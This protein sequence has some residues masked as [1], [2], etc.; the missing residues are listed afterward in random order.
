ME[1]APNVIVLLGKVFGLIGLVGT[2]L[3]ASAFF[4][5][6]PPWRPVVSSASVFGFFLVIGIVFFLLGRRGVADTEEILA[7]G[8]KQQAKLTRILP[9]YGRR[10]VYR[11]SIY[12]AEVELEAGG[13]TI[14]SKVFFYGRDLAAVKQLIEAQTPVVVRF[15][16]DYPNRVLFAEA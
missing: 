5:L 12:A 8:E 3:M 4:A 13:G 9:G 6:P 15:L 10:P 2:L 7:R 11:R 14:R 16:P 1:N